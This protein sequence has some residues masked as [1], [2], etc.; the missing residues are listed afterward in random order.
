MPRRGRGT[1]IIWRRL[2]GEGGTPPISLQAEWRAARLH[3][4]FGSFSTMTPR[5]F[6]SFRPRTLRA[7]RRG[8]PLVSRPRRRGLR[9]RCNRVLLESMGWTLLCLLVRGRQKTDRCAEISASGFFTGSKDFQ[10]IGGG[11]LWVYETVR[12]TYVGL[13]LVRF[14]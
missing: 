6:M 11:S 9:S 5:S 7:R 13:Y 12:W 10:D 3:G 2:I 8:I 4:E 1:S 14:R